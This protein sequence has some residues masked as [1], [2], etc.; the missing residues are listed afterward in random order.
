MKKIFTSALILLAVNSYAQIP[1][2]GMENWTNYTV[3]GNPLE[4]PNSWHGSDEAVYWHDDT[5]T[6]GPILNPEKQVFG[7]NNEHSGNS[8]AR[9]ESLPV[10][11]FL[12]ND[13]FLTGAIST[14]PMAYAVLAVIPVGPGIPVTEQVSYVYAWTQ[15]TS[16]SGDDTGS[17]VV[18]AYVPGS[19]G[20]SV[21]GTGTVDIPPSGA[22]VQTGVA[23]QYPDPNVTPTY[24]NITF[25][26]SKNMVGGADT[27]R[28]WVDDISWS[29]ASA[30]NVVNSKAVKVYP[31]PSSGIVSVYNT[32]T[33]AVTVKAFTINGQQVA[34]KT[35]T[36]NDVLD[37][38]AQASG[39]YFFTVTDKAGKTV[40]HGKLTIAK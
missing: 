24:V 19:N 2:A 26:S 17:L 28:L 13:I 35:F 31:N 4:R 32:L 36:G 23:V 11:E 38:T 40:Q 9:I 25:Y 37:L 21:V 22:Y 27:S 3:N 5:G 33:E 30:K 7:S 12:G 14:A 16:Q 29:T 6:F 18:T 8:A 39:L 10:V 20:D 1:N 34:E 15:Y